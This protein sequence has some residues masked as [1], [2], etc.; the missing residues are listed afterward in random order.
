MRPGV[1]EHDGRPCG[2]R[3]EDFQVGPHIRD[4]TLGSTG[5]DDP[6]DLAREDHRNHDD[7]VDA[8]IPQEL[9]LVSVEMLSDLTQVVLVD[10]RDE[11]RPAS[12]HDL[13]IHRPVKPAATGRDPRLRD[14]DWIG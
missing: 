1:V 3:L 5:H 8:E 10:R 13:G 14:L 7:C 12:P 9:E 6:G 11:Q 4:G 2:K